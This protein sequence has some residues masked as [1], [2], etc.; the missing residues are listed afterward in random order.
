MDHHIHF[1]KEQK[2]HLARLLQTSAM[3]QFGIFGY[4]GWS[5]SDWLLLLL[6]FLIL[7]MAE[8]LSMALLSTIKSE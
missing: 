3:A 4:K 1:N 5:N 8:S 7:I 6:S 2:Q